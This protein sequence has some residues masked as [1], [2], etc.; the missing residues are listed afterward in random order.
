MKN[1][2]Y[3]RK[4]RPKTKEELILLPKVEKEIKD[5][6]SN[7][8][9]FYGTCGLGKTTLAEILSEPYSTLKINASLDT[10]ID[11]IREN[12]SNFINKFS[13]SDLEKDGTYKVIILDEFERLSKNTLDAL[14][15]FVE[16]CDSDVRFIAT[17]NH[18]HK[19]DANVMSRFTKLDFDPHTNEEKQFLKDALIKY[20]RNIAT[21]E[22]I[23]LT[24]ENIIDI[25]NVNFPDARSMCNVL[26]SIKVTGEYNPKASSI[27]QDLAKSVYKAI[28]K[29]ENVDVLYAISLEF[30]Y[31]IY[32]LFDILGRPFIELLM[33]Q[34][35]N[36]YRD[37]VDDITIMVTKYAYMF[38]EKLDPVVHAYALLA[39]LKKIL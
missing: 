5:G 28:L 8:F 3:W 7:N 20:L 26:Q 4:Y 19:I 6:L 9:V 23:S 36:N 32:Q 22:D 38:S 29:K 1:E 33:K 13:L 10:N 37:K 24:D 12:A 39:E 27:S 35:A 21:I 14:K 17:T 16:Q 11:M 34:T 18:I 25:V 30:E 31:D 15:G 2:L